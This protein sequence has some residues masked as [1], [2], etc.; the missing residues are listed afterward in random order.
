MAERTALYRHFDSDGRL[1]YVGIS[2]SAV[3]RLGQHQQHAHWFG[4]IVRVDIEWHA[5][6]LLALEA[7]AYAI[8][9]EN[10]LHNTARPQPPK[11]ATL[12]AYQRTAEPYS[13]AI[14][15]AASGRRDG[16]YFDEIDA[17]EM[18]AWWRSEF[19]DEEFDIVS[20]R[21]G[22]PDWP[23]GATDGALPLRTFNAELWSAT[24]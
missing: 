19:P 22:D 14:V 5:T 13:F 18:L 4:A 17:R 11:G 3:R 2:L 6:R 23:R 24:A 15:H 21:S 1:L 9:R 10:P 16:N 8:A 12:L 7:E 20:A